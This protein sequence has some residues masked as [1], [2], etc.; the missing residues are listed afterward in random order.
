[1]SFPEWTIRKLV[2]ERRIP[3]TRVN[4]RL[5]FDHTKIDDWPTKNTIEPE[6]P[7]YIKPTNDIEKSRNREIN[8]AHSID[9]SSIRQLNYSPMPRK[10]EQFLFLKVCTFFC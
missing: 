9:G 8:S 4:R 7:E 10:K 1:V 2:Q 6:K 5:Y 3:V